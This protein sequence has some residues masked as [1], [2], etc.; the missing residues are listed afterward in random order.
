MSPVFNIYHKEKTIL[1]F[2][3]SNLDCGTIRFRND[4]RSEIWVYEVDNKNALIEKIIPF[5]QKFKFLSEKK[6][7]LHVLLK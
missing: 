4:S 1:S 5:F 7:I 3:K 2:I 6:E